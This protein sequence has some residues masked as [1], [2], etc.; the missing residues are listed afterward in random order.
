MRG[1]IEREEAWRTR[2]I[3][4]ADNLYTILVKMLRSLGDL[5]PLASRGEVPLRNEAGTLTEQSAERLTSIWSCLDEAEVLL[6]HLELLFSSD[7]AAYNEAMQAMKALQRAAGLLDG[8]AHAQLLIRAVVAERETSGAGTELLREAEPRY[9]SDLAA[10][11][12]RGSCPDVFDP[13]DD[14]NVARWAR[15]LHGVAGD[16]AHAYAGAARRYVE[17]YRLSRTAG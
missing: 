16:R 6:G 2:L 1:R 17:A 12:A 10:L 5:L 13:S 3:E 11:V 4:S 7:G 14:A 8:R 9:L 15:E